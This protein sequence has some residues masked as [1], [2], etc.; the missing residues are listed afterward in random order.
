MKRL[1]KIKLFRTLIIGPRLIRPLASA[2]NLKKFLIYLLTF[3]NYRLILYIL[4]LRTTLILL[5]TTY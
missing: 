3:I 5:I 4:I 2:S 1:L